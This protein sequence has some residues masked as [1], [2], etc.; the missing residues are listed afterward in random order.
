MFDRLKSFGRRK[1][2]AWKACSIIGLFLALPVLIAWTGSATVDFMTSRLYARYITAV[3]QKTLTMEGA[4]KW[5]YNLHPQNLINNALLAVW[6]GGSRYGAPLAA[7]GASGGSIWAVPDGWNIQGASTGVTR[8]DA[9]DAIAGSGSSVYPGF[10]HSAYVQTWGTAT[11]TG[12]TR[13][14]TYPG[15]NGVSTTATW[16][17][18]FAGQRVTFGAWVKR[19][20][21]QYTA[22]GVSTYFIRPFINTYANAG[23]LA[24]ETSF[25]FGSYQATNGW[26]CV[27]ATTTVPTAATALEV[28]F[29]MNPTVLA[30][31][32]GDSAYVCGPFLYVNPVDSAF[33]P[34]PQEIVYLNR[35]LDVWSGGSTFTAQLGNN[36]GQSI[37]LSTGAGWKGIIPDSAKAI[38]C[39]IRGDFASTADPLHFYANM[40]DSGVT[41]YPQVTAGVA[42]FDNIWIP[43]KADGTFIVDNV[44]AVTGVSLIVNAV[45]VR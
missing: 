8:Y 20:T 28:G 6:S 16:Y 41:L 1:I 39:T 40:L 3:P 43:L 38:Y 18:Q 2:P 15:T 13:Y 21:A 26:E 7:Y 23:Y 10:P 24:G 14:F 35:S 45:Q 29:A 17:R 31:V 44:A 11:G 5:S 36:V 42:S 37:D 22:T 27:T 4:V 19:D 33:A 12:T 32:G 30:A 9:P 25:A 34:N